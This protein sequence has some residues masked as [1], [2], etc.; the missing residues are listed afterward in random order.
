MS[1]V[2]S[3]CHC[4]FIACWLLEFVAH[5]LKNK[6]ICC[7]K[8]LFVVIKRCIRLMREICRKINQDII[9]M[10]RKGLKLLSTM[11]HRCSKMKIIKRVDSCAKRIKDKHQNHPKLGSWLVI[12]EDW[13]HRKC[14]AITVAKHWR[15][16]AR[17]EK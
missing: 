1:I 11:L 4:Y 12:T 17:Y 7:L 8:L 2:L 3:S 16:S 13:M 5:I 6:G 14:F 10:L 15:C 9:G